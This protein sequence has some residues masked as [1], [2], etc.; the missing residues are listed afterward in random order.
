MNFGRILRWF[1][2][3]AGVVLLVLAA[4]PALD[5]ATPAIIPIV[6]AFGRLWLI[7][8]LL[9]AVLAIAIRAWAAALFNL[10][11]AGTALVTLVGF[12]GAACQ[13]ADQELRVLALNA[14][15]AQVSPTEIAKS[16]VEHDFQLVFLLE[17]DED[18]VNAVIGE[19]PDDQLTA[20]TAGPYTDHNIA[21]SVILSSFP[22][23]EVPDHTSRESTFEQP[24]AR[25]DVDGRT[26]VV[27]AIHPVSPT[28]HLVEHWHTELTE[29]GQWQRTQRGIPL[30]MAGDFN[31]SRGHP[32]FRYA[33]QGMNNATGWWASATWPA[34]RIFGPWVDIDHVM[35]RGFRADNTQTLD[36][37]R[38]DHRGIA[39]TLQFCRA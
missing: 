29:L 1:A 31:A 12:N 38:S 36:F 2:V 4:A 32:V 25:V 37:D 18:L 23:T 24:I 5:R 7:A 20:S 9:V 28:P 16:I 26:V 39:T 34:G 14:K 35:Y 3:G 33:T 6:Q 10:L 13:I 27:R 17:V 11:A 22:L 15:E 8:A 21:G 30:I 19:L